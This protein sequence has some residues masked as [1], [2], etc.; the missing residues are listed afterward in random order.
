MNQTEVEPYDFVKALLK[1]YPKPLKII[2]YDT[3]SDRVEWA[4]RLKGGAGI[5]AKLNGKF[6][7]IKGK[8]KGRSGYWQ[9][10]GGG[11][12][13]GEDL[14]EAAIREFREETGLDVEITGL[15]HI[16]GYIYKSEGEQPVF[17]ASALFEGI[18]IG[19]VMKTSDLGEV[20]EVKLFDEV[21]LDQLVPWQRKEISLVG[22]L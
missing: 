11:M 13:S 8:L 20:A 18:V 22:G 9:L 3:S 15:H 1:K 17:L 4:R 14:E 5:M 7:L 21:P 10:P 2:H 12:R 6:V 19:G 16:V